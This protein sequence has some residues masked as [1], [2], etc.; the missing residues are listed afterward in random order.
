MKK[1]ELS[2]K[3]NMDFDSVLKFFEDFMDGFKKR[4]IVVQKGDEFVTLK[5]ADMMEFEVEAKEKKGKQK[6]SIEL[7]W[8]EEVSLTEDEPLKVCSEE[9]KVEEAP[10]EEPA[11]DS[12]AAAPAGGAKAVET[13]EDDKTKTAAAAKKP[14][15][16]KK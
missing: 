8:R 1:Q 12:T 16:G 15:T 9:P 2:V 4:T 10:A 5:P 7:S 13:K 11:K 14:A 3:G 6:L